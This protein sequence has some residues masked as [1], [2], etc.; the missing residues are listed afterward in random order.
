MIDDQCSTV[1]LHAQM[2][3]RRRSRLHDA[4]HHAVGSHLIGL[5]R[6]HL[7]AQSGRIV[8]DGHWS[9]GHNGRRIGRLGWWVT[10]WCFGAAD[11]RVGYIDSHFPVRTSVVSCPVTTSFAT[12]TSAA[13]ARTPA[14]CSSATPCTHT[15]NKEVKPIRQNQ[16]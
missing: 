4:A 7:L 5:S 6:H 8:I 10:R 9:V 11:E 1:V 12:V 16:L 13:T 14:A 3:S 2:I 15:Q